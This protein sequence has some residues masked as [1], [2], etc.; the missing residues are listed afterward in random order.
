MWVAVAISLLTLA[1]ILVRPR[2]L[3][4]TSG[5]AIGAALMVATQQ[6]PL[7]QALYVLQ[8]NA[9]VLLFFV[10]LM[11][12]SAMAER[13]GFFDWA[14]GK[15]TSLAHG[16]GRMLFLI[17][18]ALGALVTAFLSNDATALIL[19]P[20]VFALVSQL[21]LDPLPFMFAT[22]FIAN[23]AS[24]LLPIS[25]PVNLLAVDAFDLR[26]GGYLRYLLAPSVA[27]IAINIGLFLLIFRKGIPRRF[28]THPASVSVHRDSFFK[29]TG[30]VLG[31][32]AAGYMVLSHY[33]LPLSLAAM[34]G[35]AILMVGGAFFRKLQ[36][37]QIRSRMS[38]SILV[39]IFCL[40]V[41]VKGLENSGVIAAIAG[42]VV[43][44]ASGSQFVA[45]LSVTVA[46]ALGSNLV[47]NW[48]MMMV[49]VSSLQHAFSANGLHPGVAYAA[50][51]GADVGPNL[52]VIGSLSSMLWLVL[53][54]QRGLDVRP[55]TYFKLGIIIVPPMLLVGAA[56]IY[57]ATL[58]P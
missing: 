43:R 17:V 34:G 25:N 39:F 23:T 22:G 41:V 54:R 56:L 6:A 33:A 51:L 37:T 19:T 11:A 15:A 53:L 4:E 36:W 20:V 47:N 10:G 31:I 8:A 57:V 38:W 35:A 45:I 52:T 7:F 28:P 3:S 46:T 18:F 14:A 32:T 5:A 26:L 1:L 50:I 55:L 27:S 44:M 13:A 12:I 29:F 42:A 58:F 9:N 48:S 30:I 24:S 40:A 2:P 21:K 16:N 49:S